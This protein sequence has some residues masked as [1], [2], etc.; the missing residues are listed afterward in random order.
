MG[1][2]GPIDRVD[3]ERLSAELFRPPFWLYLSHR[4]SSG[5]DHVP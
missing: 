5:R 4:G 3:I 1:S 2:I